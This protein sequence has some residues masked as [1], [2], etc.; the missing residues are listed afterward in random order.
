[1][2]QDSQIKVFAVG[3]PDMDILR[4]PNWHFRRENKNSVINSVIYSLKFQ[5]FWDVTPCR[6]IKLPTF[7]WSVVPPS[8]RSSRPEFWT[9]SPWTTDQSTRY[10]V[11]EYYRC[12]KHRSEKS[13]FLTLLPL[14][15]PTPQKFQYIPHLY[16]DADKFLA[17]SGWKKIESSLF[18]RPTRRS[19]MPRRLG[20]SSS[21]PRAYAPD[22]P[23]PCRLIVL[24][25]YYSSILDVPTFVTGPSSSS[26]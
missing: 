13:R 2:K 4:L 22:A 20:S 16:R 19:L 12:Q 6:L 23:Q 17:R 14:P 26:M 9:A 3:L 24:P 11:P 10:N 21:G 1:M 7:R 18:L 25:S 8:S 5:V 15:T